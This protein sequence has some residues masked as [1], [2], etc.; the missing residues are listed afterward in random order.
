MAKAV[1]KIHGMTCAAC[2][3]RIEKGLNKVSGVKSA[4]VNLAME[5]ASIEFDESQASVADFEK[6]VADV[7]YKVIKDKIELD[8][9][10]MTCAAC[11]T[12]IEKGLNKISG[13]VNANVNLALERATIEYNSGEVSIAD[14]IKKVKD[15]G[16]KAT[17]RKGDNV[18][19]EK[20]ARESEIKSQKRKLVI[21]AILSLPLLFAMLEYVNVEIPE[22]FL[23]PWFQWIFATPIQFYVGWQFYKG[24]YKSLKSGSANMDVLI[25]LGTTAAYIYSLWEGFTGG[26]DLYYETAA[27][28][29]TLIV[30]GK[31]L[32]AIAKGRTS[33][34]IKKLM[35][36]QAKTALVIRD[37]EETEIA[38]EDVTLGDHI[39]VRPGEKIPV[40]GKIVEGSSA[41][42]ESMLTGESIPVDKKIGDEVIGATLNKNGRIVFEA[43]KVGK[44]TA[45]AQIIKVVED[46]QGSKAPIQKLAD[47]IS[48]VFVPIVVA[49]AILTFII[50]YFVIGVSFVIALSATIAVLVI[51][52]PCALGLATPTS[53]MVGTGK[54]AEK[55]VL[56][57]GG[58]HLQ[59]VQRLNTIVLDKTGT[60]T[61]GEPE[62]TDVISGVGFSDEDVLYLT[63]SAERSSEHPLGQAIVK[64]AKEK[65]LELVNASSFNA[66]PGH[67]L[68]AEVD[69]KT[70]YIGTRKLMK[71]KEIAYESL[72][73]SMVK[74][75]NDGKTA[76]LISIDGKLA[77]VV[78]VADTVKEDSKE[79][80][81][82][83]RDLGLKVVMITGDNQ[84]TANAIAKQVGVTEIRAEV[85]PEDKAKEVQQFKDN[86]EIVAM[87]G[88]G[89]NDA[90]ALVTAD[91]GI[92]I[93]TGTDV[94]IEAAD[95]TLMRGNLTGI[96]DAIILSRKTMLNIKQNL[97]WAFFYNTA[98]IPVAALG[99]L[100][101]WI[102]GAAMAFS[103]VS[104]VSNSLRLKR[105]KL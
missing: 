26:E 3:T 34:A 49:I 76:M 12:R 77:G 36:L 51:A 64:G 42:D 55:G 50:W 15:I 103:S 88:D 89:I 44:D 11:A 65:G 81:S 104:V 27:I 48:G 86:G 99:L 20:E 17:E 101:P 2:A 87:V 35:G 61:K 90:P 22:I 47:K 96:V 4:N 25:A 21:S 8:I 97:F 73:D 60:I 6:K 95:V 7:G 43:T 92:A 37:G 19:A 46:A 93:G 30:L 75:E 67:G 59:N 24:S 91:V 28:I 45:L 53:I 14:M 9:Q 82:K 1:L 84:R 23:N 94:A 78:A 54:G 66:I 98:G 62:L 80:I 83:L 79:A 5:R 16:Y 70:L 56:F 10:G 105:V 40:D 71:L 41:I 38:I 100:A 39:I 32:E 57:K 68:E 74:M 63:A 58:E 29:I 69:G 18:D 72:E 52:C 31:L 13:V 33:E 102:A 85:L